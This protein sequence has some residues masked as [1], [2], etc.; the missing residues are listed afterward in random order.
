MDLPA[1][2]YQDLGHNRYQPTRATVGPWSPELQH[3]GPPIGLLAHALRRHPCE[4]P[5]QIAR[6][7][8]EILG[9]MPLTPCEIEVEVVRPG[10]RIELL[11]GTM[12]SA[13]RVLLMAHA[14]RL[15]PVAGIAPEVPADW[16]APPLPES[17]TPLTF[18]GLPPFPYGEAM[19]WRFVEGAMNRLGPATVWARPRL[20]LVDS[21][22]IDGLE[23][24]LVML[25]SANGVSAELDIRRWTFVPVDLQL[26][27]TRHPDGEWFG[28]AARTV[29]A[30]DG[31]G[32]THTHLFDRRGALG[33]SQHTLFVRPR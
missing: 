23:A 11:R 26:N 19:E 1:T 17:A 30:D 8:V 5:M 16:A 3:G 15:E 32:L 10:R 33:R 13:G 31:I 12:R 25:D 6:L 22:P 4:G 21:A 7:T 24:L 28:M 20:P 2:F 9:P 29:I 27:V 14:W 18:A